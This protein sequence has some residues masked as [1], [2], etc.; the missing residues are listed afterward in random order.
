MLAVPAVGPSTPGTRAAARHT[1]REP[2]STDLPNELPA[3]DTS[4][5]FPGRLAR[6][7]R[8]RRPPRLGHDR[9]D[10]DMNRIRAAHVPFP[11][12]RAG[13]HPVLAAGCPGWR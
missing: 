12:I 1:Q 9:P 8:L 6:V 11:P 7:P 5:P 10:R 4:A 13:I 2:G 3:G